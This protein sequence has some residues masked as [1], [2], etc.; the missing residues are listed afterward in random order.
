MTTNEELLATAEVELIKANKTGIDV[1]DLQK[2]INTLH[3]C[4]ETQQDLSISFSSAIL[5]AE[6]AGVRDL[7]ERKKRIA[8]QVEKC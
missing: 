7:Q 5:F 3:Y 1:V 2:A 4:I 6:I 8:I